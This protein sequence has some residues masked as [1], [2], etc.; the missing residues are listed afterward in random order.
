MSIE[1]A[2]KLSIERKLD[3]LTL[4]QCKAACLQILVMG[5]LDMINRRKKKK[6]EKQSDRSQEILSTFMRSM[7]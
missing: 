2:L 7:I 5:S 3:L 4:R 6:P 1:D